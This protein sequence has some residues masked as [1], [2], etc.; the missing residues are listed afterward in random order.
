[1]KVITPRRVKG[2][3]NN[4]DLAVVDICPTCGDKHIH[5]WGSGPREPDCDV[6][7]YPMAPQYYLKCN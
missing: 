4:V 2:K 5:G 1:M 7:R 6:K 3:G